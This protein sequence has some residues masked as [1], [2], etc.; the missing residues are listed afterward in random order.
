[1]AGGLGRAQGGYDEMMFRAM[2]RDDSHFYDPLGLESQALRVSFQGTANAYLY[3]TRFVSWLAYNYSP[4]TLAEWTRRDP[5]SKRYYADQFEHVF[6]IPLNQAWQNWIAFE[7]EFQQRNLA[8]VRKFPI[9]PDHKLVARAL[10]SVSRMFY[11]EATGTLYAAVRYPGYSRA[12]RRAEHAR[13][14]RAES[15]RYQRRNAL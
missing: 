15:R 8:E 14:K 10:G 6:G 9:T 5:G 13:R 3:G 4:E 1:M 11:E 12:Y 2:V 7:R